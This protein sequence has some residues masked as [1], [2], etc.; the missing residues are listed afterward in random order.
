MKKETKKI[1]TLRLQFTLPP[2]I[3]RELIT[4]EHTLDKT[5]AHVDDIQFDGETFLIHK[6]KAQFYVPLTGVYYWLEA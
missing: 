1:K 3:Y 6:G 4:T 5:F 2:P